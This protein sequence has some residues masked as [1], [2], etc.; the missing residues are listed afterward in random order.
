MADL[1]SLTKS[2]GSKIGSATTTVGKATTGVISSVVGGTY[3]TISQG[4]K[5]ATDINELRPRNIA[6]ATLD[7]AGLGAIMPGLMGDPRKDDSVQS[8]QR[9]ADQNKSMAASFKPMEELLQKLININE[10]IL[11]NSNAL[12]EFAKKQTS[13][14]DTS[15]ELVKKQMLQDIEN[16][17]EAAK[18]TAKPPTGAN[19]NV[20]GAEKK[21]GGFLSGIMD[22]IKGV[23]GFLAPIGNFIS[24]IGSV[25][26]GLARFAVRFLGPIGILAGIFLALERQDWAMMFDNLSK[27]FGDL[28]DGKILDGLVRMIGTIGDVL[29]KG[30]GRIFTG[31]LSFF[32]FKDL[33]KTI[34]DW[35]DNFNLADKLVEWFHALTDWLSNFGKMLADGAKWIGKK[36][37]DFVAGIWDTI[38]GSFGAL[39]KDI[40]DAFDAFSSGDILTGIVKAIYAIPNAIIQWIGRAAA[41]IIELFGGAELAKSIREFLDNFNI[42]D[43]IIGFFS[44]VKNW[45]VEKF[46]DAT[47]A[48]SDW[49]NSFSVIDPILNTFKSVKDWMVEKFDNATTAF[50]EWWNSFSVIDIV[51]TP[52]NYLKDTAVTMFDNLYNAVT[53]LFSFDLVGKIS[54]TIGNVISSV[55]NFFKELPTKAVDLIADFLPDSLKSFFKSMFGNGNA[56]TAQAS[57]TRTQT[58]A[59]PNERNV[60]TAIQ[61]STQT[62]SLVPPSE[63][64]AE[65]SGRDQVFNQQSARMSVVQSQPPVIINNSTNTNSGGGANQN[66]PPR[67]SGAV[68]TSPQ[69]SHIDRALYGDYYGAGVA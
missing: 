48:F 30:L 43:T 52:F 49:W 35:L 63:I 61:A 13:S 69:S 3:D 54:D 68:Q 15:N 20:A 24:S 18:A 41:T 59:I 27:V 11:E 2:V 28:A 58:A 67:T 45:V 16:A 57:G 21:S 8:A 23:L 19:D 9:V 34:D 50:G 32:G 7:A 53:E 37:G 5:R 60:S 1:S 38:S 64:G 14:L 40:T 62:A 65:Q 66:S 39:F 42:A 46:T 10:K 31:I 6:A 25:L 51:L 55:W 29:L 22:S 4:F 47:K 26:A 12:I 44:S 17:R 33:A 36:I 56:N